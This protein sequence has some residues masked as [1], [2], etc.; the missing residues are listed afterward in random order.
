MAS[1]D[2]LIYNWLHIVYLYEIV[3]LLQ[4]QFNMLTTSNVNKTALGKVN[5]NMKLLLNACCLVVRFVHLCIKVLLF[6][7]QLIYQSQRAVYTF[8]LSFI[9]NIS[10]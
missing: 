3:L 5:V 2:W 8:T 1:I 6:Y 4:H 9:P 10:F 7:G